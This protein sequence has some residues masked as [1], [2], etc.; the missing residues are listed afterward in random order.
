MSEF[1][2]NRR[3]SLLSIY[4]LALTNKGELLESARKDFSK[5]FMRTMQYYVAQFCVDVFSYFIIFL[6]L[7]FNFNIALPF[8]IIYN[9]LL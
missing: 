4:I 7:N 8:I 6:S 1:T 9:T 2:T 5:E 3:A